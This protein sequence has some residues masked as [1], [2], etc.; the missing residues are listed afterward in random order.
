MRLRGT[1]HAARDTR[2]VPKPTVSLRSVPAR[3]TAACARRH[4][5]G[6][7]LQAFPDQRLVQTGAA[8]AEG[9]AQADGTVAPV[10]APGR[11]VVGKGLQ[12]SGCQAQV[13]MF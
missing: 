6:P 8:C 4:P 5:P 2:A 10:T 3:P 13:P 11:D 12:R 1:V 9:G 7:V